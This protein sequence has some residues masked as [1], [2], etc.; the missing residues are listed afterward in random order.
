MIVWIP[1]IMTLPQYDIYSLV[2]ILLGNEPIL[3][4]YL[5]LSLKRHIQLCMNPSMPMPFALNL[6]VLQV[7]LDPQTWMHR[8]GDD[9]VQHSEVF[10]L[11]YALPLPKWLKGFVH[12]N[13]YVE[14][15]SVSPYLDC[16]LIALD[17]YSWCSSYWHRRHC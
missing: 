13:M 2:N 1:L 6:Y 3:S 14:L 5:P 16:R 9:C 8:N 4:V 7:P 17:K 10:E 11:D 12:H 15:S